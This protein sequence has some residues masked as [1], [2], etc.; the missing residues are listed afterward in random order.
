MSKRKIFLILEIDENYKPAVPE[1]GKE[2]FPNGYF[3]FNITKI[4]K[5]Y[6]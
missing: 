5:I 6:K 3:V 2:Y 4:L 1:E